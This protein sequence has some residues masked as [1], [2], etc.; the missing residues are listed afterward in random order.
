MS[1]GDHEPGVD[2]NEYDPGR[3]YVV[4]GGR[5]GTGK[6][7]LDLVTLIVATSEPQPT[8]Q[9]EAAGILRLCESP[10]SV[11]EI[12]AYTDLPI[13]LVMVILA[14]LLKDEHVEARAPVPKALLPER[15]LI[16]AVMHGLQKL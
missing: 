1:E 14:D 16:E 3:M 11:A 6:A 8:I 2:E 13:S 12:S 5:T 9:P 7:A 10:L 4:T 15:A